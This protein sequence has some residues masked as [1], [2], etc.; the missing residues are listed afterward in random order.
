MKVLVINNI[1]GKEE[2]FENVKAVYYPNLMEFAIVL[3]DGREIIFNDSRYSY[4][5]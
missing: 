3:E 4:R 5:Y 1:T 2:T